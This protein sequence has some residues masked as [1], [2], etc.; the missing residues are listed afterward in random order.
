MITL[1][2]NISIR[3]RFAFALKC[4]TNY[5]DKKNLRTNE[6]DEIILNFSKFTSAT[7][8]ADWYD[9]CK[10]YTPYF[11]RPSEQR[12]RPAVYKCLDNLKGSLL[13]AYYA[14][15]D[16]QTH[17]LFEDTFNVA[18]EHLFQSINGD[19]T[20]TY[21]EKIIEVLEINHVELPEINRVAFSTFDQI[22]GWG[23]DFDWESVWK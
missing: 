11:N 23:D 9:C 2:R 16:K 20:L 8:L 3:G 12:T 5:L 22:S 18:V 6:S 1:F 7:N 13:V 10:E 17:H 14:K 15:I 4:L 19:R 21:L